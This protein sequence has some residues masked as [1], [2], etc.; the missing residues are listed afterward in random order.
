ML[1]HL[2]LL[3]TLSSCNGPQRLVKGG[4]KQRNFVRV[5]FLAVVADVKTL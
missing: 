5:S 2:N 4:L 1:T 3:H